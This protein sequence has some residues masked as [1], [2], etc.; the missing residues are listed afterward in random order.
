MKELIENS[1]LTI[2]L[3]LAIMLLLLL[4]SIAE[5]SLLSIN[6]YR[7]YHSAQKGSIISK[8]IVK[9]IEKPDSL[10]SILLLGNSFL[11]NLAAT[12]VTLLTVKYLSDEY[13][14]LNITLLTLVSLVLLEIAPKTLAAE[15]PEK[16][17][18]FSAVFCTVIL[19]LL[20]PL[21]WLLRSIT[22]LILFPFRL[23]YQKTHRGKDSLNREEI[24]SLIT[25]PGSILSKQN[26]KMLSSILDLETVKVEE[27]MTA[28]K[29]IVAID[30]DNEWSKILNRIKHSS[31]SVMPVYSGEYSNVLGTI[32]TRHLLE[33]AI[34]GRLNKEQ[35]I[36][37]I[38]KIEFT[39]EGTS[40][41]QQLINFQKNKQKIGLVVDELGSTIG[42]I[43]LDAINEEIIGAF[44]DNKLLGFGKKI[45]PDGEQDN[46]YLVHGSTSLRM[47][48]G[49]LPVHL[50]SN[51]VKT[52]NGWLLEKLEDF[53]HAG[54]ELTTDSCTITIMK[55]SST[56]I[57]WAKIQLKPDE[58]I[59]EK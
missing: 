2:I 40:L 46:R 8:L 17:A 32:N 15:F 7:V 38:D 43:T 39:Q 57:V 21:V 27:I 47:L 18:P 25:M 13:L 3:F 53:P 4:F 23:F 34:N 14:Y 48:N 24:K 12:L 9:L 55:V 56:F 33:M 30:C 20:Y 44:T 10:L 28:R 49:A 29:D 16:L 22:K 35:F 19:K 52:F 1:A 11:N 36:K 59:V 58:A 6:R 31:H 45:I 51:T 41:G 26:K 54:M 50:T 42:M 37:S 5:T